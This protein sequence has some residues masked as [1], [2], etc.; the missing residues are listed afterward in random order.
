MPFVPGREMPITVK[1]KNKDRQRVKNRE[2]NGR[3]RRNSEGN[4]GEDPS[5]S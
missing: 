2:N 5:T 3:G 1:R 4:A